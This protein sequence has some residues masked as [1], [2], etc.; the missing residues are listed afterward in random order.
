MLVTSAG[1][2]AGTVGGGRIETK[3]IG[4][5]RE[6]LAGAAEA[7]QVADWN[8]QHDVGM[9][10]GGTV[11]LLFE[12][13]NVNLWSVVIFGA[14]HVSQMLVRILAIN[15][16]CRIRCLDPRAEWVNKLPECPNVERIHA[17]SWEALPRHVA[18]LR[19]TD[20]I[21]C[22]TQGHATDKPILA[23]ILGSGRTFAYVGVIGSAA[24]RKVL[25]RELMA[26]EIRADAAADFRCPIGIC[27]AGGTPIG[28]NDPA[29][30]ALSIAA[31]L[32]SVR[33]EAR[34]GA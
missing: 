12:P 23:A 28:S 10:C 16:R 4:F 5:A 2:Q 25:V 15:P 30:I 21:V 29:E 9:T 34:T 14:G 31:D 26:A 32:L 1:L 20:Q 6:L 11:A 19:D 8:L 22:V 7:P 13:F 17:E 24:K 18:Q 3:A 33:S 27:H